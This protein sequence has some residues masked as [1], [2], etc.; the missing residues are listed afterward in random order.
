MTAV[1]QGAR[2]EN[3]EASDVK[4]VRELELGV[5]E[6]KHWHTHGLQERLGFEQ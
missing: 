1:H 2:G 4:Q 5:F 3:T 6:R